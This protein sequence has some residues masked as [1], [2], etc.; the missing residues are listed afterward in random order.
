MK[1]SIII[2]T[3]NEAAGIEAFESH[4]LQRINQAQVEC[5]VLFSDGFSSDGTYDKIQSLKIQA[6]SGRAAQMNAAAKKA[7]GDLLF[8]LHADSRIHEK[9]LDAIASC[10]A[11]W[12]CFRLAFD[13]RHPLL[14]I[15]AFNSDLRVRLRR[16]VFGDQGIFIKKDLFERIQGFANLPI[17]ED[18]QLSLDLKKLGIKPHRINLPILTSARRFLET[19]VLK[20]M[21]KMQIYQHQFR[22]GKNIHAI[23][24][25][26]EAKDGKGKKRN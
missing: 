13:H 11:P 12:G 15:I 20:T 8:F 5:E 16:V 7:T 3:W 24:K 6:A 9:A 23:Q 1:I 25:E 2:P 26:Y 22:R 14:G 4:L 17:M 19:G 21:V 18:Y 10:E